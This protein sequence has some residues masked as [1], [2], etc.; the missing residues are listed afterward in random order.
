MQNEV[1]SVGCKCVSAYC[2]RVVPILVESRNDPS[3]LVCRASYRKN[4]S[5]FCRKRSSRGEHLKATSVSIRFEVESTRAPTIIFRHPGAGRDP[6]QQE[7]E[8]RRKPKERLK[9]SRQNQGNTSAHGCCRL[10]W[11]PAFAGM[12]RDEGIATCPHFGARRPFAPCLPLP[13]APP[14]KPSNDRNSNGRRACA[15]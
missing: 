8:H 7:I 13:A 11:V 14:Y 12:T 3:S 2:T 5:H 10:P 4:R 6:R 1:L 15:A 9:T